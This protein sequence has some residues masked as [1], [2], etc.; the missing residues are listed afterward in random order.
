M[1]LWRERFRGN[2][3]RLRD[4]GYSEQFLRLWDYYFCYCEGGF[5]EH[6]IGDVQLLL[7]RSRA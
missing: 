6:T 1:R 7:E 5:L 3:S 4:L 2:W